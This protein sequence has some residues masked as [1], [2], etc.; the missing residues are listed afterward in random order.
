MKRKREREGYDIPLRILGNAGK[1]EKIYVGQSI[2]SERE[3]QRG[4]LRR[5]RREKKKKS[6]VKCKHPIFEDVTMEERFSIAH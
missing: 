3:R 5:A 4:K 2:Q 6:A 1:R